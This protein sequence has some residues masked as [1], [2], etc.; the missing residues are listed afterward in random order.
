MAIWTDTCESAASQPPNQDHL[1]GVVAVS[2]PPSQGELDRVRTRTGY[3][4]SVSRSV[5]ALA[6]LRPF[7]SDEQQQSIWALRLSTNSGVANML[8]TRARTALVGVAVFVAAMLGGTQSARA[9]VYRG[10]WDPIYGAPFD[11][12]GWRGAATFF[13]PDACLVGTATVANLDPCSSGGMKLLSANV[14]F[15]DAAHDPSGLNILDT[16]T[17]LPPNP[18][19]NSV[20]VTNNVLTWVN[21]RLSDPM[22]ASASIAGGGA[23]A[24]DLQFLPSTTNSVRLFHE[25]IGMDPMCAFDIPGVTDYDSRCGIND[26][27]HPPVMTLTLVPEPATAA[28]VFA[29]LVAIGLTVRRRRA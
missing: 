9:A 18:Y 2:P 7:G 28:L 12:L 13:I 29:G 19:I 14:Y 24:F 5:V 6:C 3:L 21:S 11:G 10:S 25:P 20:R 8:N 17:F 27:S 23:Y 26:Q 22:V 4:Q 16:L 15:Y 1:A